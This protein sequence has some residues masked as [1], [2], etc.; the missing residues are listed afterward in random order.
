MSPGRNASAARPERSAKT[1]AIPMP[2]SEFSTNWTV[3][4]C[5]SRATSSTTASPT[6]KMRDTRRLCEITQ[7]N[8]KPAVGI[9][10]STMPRVPPSAFASW[11]LT[12]TSS[13]SAVAGGCAGCAGV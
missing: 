10:P 1:A 5:T 7:V 2:N 9:A 4:R 6:D 12:R 8:V 3:D 11:R 13:V